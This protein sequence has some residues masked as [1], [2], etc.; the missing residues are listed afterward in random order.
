VHL[1]SFSGD[2][3]WSGIQVPAGAGNFSLTTVSRPALGSTQPPIQWVAGTL[4]LGVKRPGREADHSSLSSVEVKE[5]VELYHHS[6]STPSWRGAQ[7]KHR[8]NLKATWK[9]L[10][11]TGVLSWN[12]SPIQNLAS[13][14]W[15]FLTSFHTDDMPYMGDQST[16]SPLSS[17]ITKM[18]CTRRHINGNKWIPAREWSLQVWR[19]Y[20]AMERPLSWP[21]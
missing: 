11:N 6:P 1:V 12:Y 16:V 13:S 18:H 17:Q 8:D 3:G 4:F 15:H 14:H 7:L 19:D 21:N 5:C 9:R 10:W 2:S 20:I